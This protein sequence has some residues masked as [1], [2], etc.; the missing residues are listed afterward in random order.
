VLNLK[1]CQDYVNWVLTNRLLIN[2]HDVIVIDTKSSLI[3]GAFGINSTLWPVNTKGIILINVD[4]LNQQ[5]FKEKEI[6]FILAHEIAHIYKNHSVNTLMWNIIERILKNIDYNSPI[7]VEIFKGFL[8]LLSPNNLPPN[9]EDL[10]NNEYEADLIALN[11]ITGDLRNAISSL[12]KLSN[13]DL[14]SPSHIWELFNLNLPAMTLKQR[15]EVLKERYYSF[16]TI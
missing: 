10:K 1:T 12:Q 4:Y 5:Q 2:D 15:I 13:G 16:K 7:I 9:A 14:N 8:A 6:Q 3:A 11:Y